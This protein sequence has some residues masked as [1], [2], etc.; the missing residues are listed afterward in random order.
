VS[1][2]RHPADRR[3]PAEP[4]L[5]PGDSARKRRPSWPAAPSAARTVSAPPADH[6]DR[7]CGRRTE[8]TANRTS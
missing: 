8:W 3:C 5:L 4:I 1:L 7:A 6:Q 2:I